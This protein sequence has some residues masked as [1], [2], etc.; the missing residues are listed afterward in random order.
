[1]PVLCPA[2]RGAGLVQS[3]TARRERDGENARE[4]AGED[5]GMLHPDTCFLDPSRRVVRVNRR[6]NGWAEAATKA[7]EASHDRG[8]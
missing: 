7:R 4:H 1:M 3:V 5:L 6:L 2:P 8:V